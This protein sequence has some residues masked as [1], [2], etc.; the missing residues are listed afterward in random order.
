VSALGLVEVE[1]PDEVLQN[2]VGDAAGVAAFQANVVIDAHPGQHRDLFAAE[3]GHPPVT[4]VDRQARLLRCDL[5]A[6]GDEEI[7]NLVSAVHGSDA[8]RGGAELG[9][10]AITW[11]RRYCLIAAA[12]T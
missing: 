8:T 7:T 6:P 3:P 12:P 9:G 11:I 4:A 5:G 2:A 1:S 10:P